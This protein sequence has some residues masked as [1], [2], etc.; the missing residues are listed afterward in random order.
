MRT[1]IHSGS[2]KKLSFIEKSSEENTS[3]RRKDKFAS[4]VFLEDGN[5]S[6]NEEFFPEVLR[7]KAHT[8][9]NKRSLFHE[10]GERLPSVFKGS[11]RS[12]FSNNS[13]NQ[14]IVQQF[15]SKK[16]ASFNDIVMDS[17]ENKKEIENDE[18]P[19]KLAGLTENSKKLIFLNK[20]KIEG[21]KHILNPSKTLKVASA[22][23]RVFFLTSLMNR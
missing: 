15:F 6:Q 16:M 19:L 10:G 14:N 18:S 5:N 9:Q 1:S 8:P 20:K 4:H 12:F 21:S 3:K 23:R 2:P 13:H 17:F 11:S 22:F 7:N